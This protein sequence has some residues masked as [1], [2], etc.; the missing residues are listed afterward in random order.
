MLGIVFSVAFASFF[1]HSVDTTFLQSFLQEVR[2][3]LRSVLWMSNANA[4]LVLLE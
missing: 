1:E 2:E 4:L 3:I